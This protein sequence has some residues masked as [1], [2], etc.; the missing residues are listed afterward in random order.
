MAPGWAAAVWAVWAHKH[1]V[2]FVK[3]ADVVGEHLVTLL[4]LAHCAA[5]PPAVATVTAEVL[6]C[7]VKPV[8]HVTRYQLWPLE[9]GAQHERIHGGRHF[10]L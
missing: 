7:R 3:P 1:H 9:H 6:L 10:A 2:S 4:D 5:L 8:A